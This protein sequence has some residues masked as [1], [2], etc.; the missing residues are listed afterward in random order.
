VEYSTG[1]TGRFTLKTTWGRSLSTV[2]F[3]CIKQFAKNTTL[4]NKRKNRYEQNQN[5]FQEPFPQ[6]QAL[7]VLPTENRIGPQASW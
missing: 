1:G 2:A 5:L 4:T 7:Y 3:A 6:G